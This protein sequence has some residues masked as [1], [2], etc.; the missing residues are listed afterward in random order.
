M[1]ADGVRALRGSDT[2]PY[3]NL[4]REEA[5]LLACDRGEAGFPC[6]YLWQNEHTAVIGRC[7]NAWRECATERMRAD[8]CKLA[9]RT[10]GGGAVYH[11]LGNLNFSF[12]VP[13]AQYDLARQLGVIAGAV[14]SFGVECAFSGRNDL[15]C[16]GRKFSGNAFRFL[17]NAALHHGTLL[18]RADFARMARYLQPPQ[19]KLAAR[20]VKSVPARVV[21]LAE[22][23]PDITVEAMAEALYGAFCREYGACALEAAEAL[24]LPDYAPLAVRNADWAWNF[25]AAP[26]FDASFARRFDWGGVE[27]QL[28]LEEG[29]V[30]RCDA[31][32]DAMDAELGLRLAQVLEG[33]RFAPDDL[34]Q[35][36]EDVSRDVAA[37]LAQLKL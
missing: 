1:H 7:Q 11:D 21:N 2:A 6:L 5:L 3:R 28:R 22:M 16:G 34:A 10:T 20:G 24:S 25:G 23:A 15:L 30:A 26:A 8:G 17:K 37:W 35:A 18:L 14:R 13:R 31:Y 36:A 9:R 27:L 19:E 32:T 29:R 4:A 12:I 33:A